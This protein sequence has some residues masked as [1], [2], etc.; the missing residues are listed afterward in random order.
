MSDQGYETYLFQPGRTFV[1]RLTP[2]QTPDT[3]SVFNLLFRH[4]EAP[5][6]AA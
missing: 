5:A 1:Q 4:P 6:V 3:N 2:E